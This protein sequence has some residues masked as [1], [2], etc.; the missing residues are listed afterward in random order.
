MNEYALTFDID[1]APDFMIDHV[2]A[3]LIDRKLKAT[4][5]L[6]HDSPAVKRLL[7]HKDLFEFGIHPNFL[8][9]STQG[10]SK[11]EIMDSLTNMFQDVK[12]VRTHALFQSTY[13]LRWL[14]NNYKIKVDVSLLL[15]ET[16]NLEPHKIFVDSNSNELLRVPF[17]WEDDIQMYNPKND[18][19]LNNKKFHVQG[20]KVFNFH[21]IH[22]FINSASMIQ[23]ESLKSK[24]PI[25]S[26]TRND[27]ESS[28]NN[29]SRGVRNF[30]EEVCIHIKTKQQKSYTISEIIEMWRN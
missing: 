18:W 8:P 19:S 14:V 11:E 15:P 4:W 10:N 27:L 5:F 25:N 22:I 24:F 20:L 12:I 2:S 9:N 28:I 13:L 21:P 1:W 30:F 17:F 3:Y 7:S 6:T 26:L 29:Q 23:Y 16:P